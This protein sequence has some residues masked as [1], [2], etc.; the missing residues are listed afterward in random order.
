MTYEYGLLSVKSGLLLGYTS[1]LFWASC[2][3][4]YPCESRS[5]PIVI[6]PFILA[7]FGDIKIGRRSL[8]RARHVS[9]FPT[10]TSSHVHTCPASQTFRKDGDWRSFK[11]DLEVGVGG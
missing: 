8:D 6:V 1:L 5:R 10:E 2:L 7:T 3:S 4:R 9:A 11:Q